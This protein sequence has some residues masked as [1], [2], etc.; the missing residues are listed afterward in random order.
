V[1]T[2]PITALSSV[3]G[4]NIIVNDRTDFPHLAVVLAAMIAIS[5]ILLRWAKRQGWL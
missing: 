1:L 3:Y 4:M 2:L 5:A